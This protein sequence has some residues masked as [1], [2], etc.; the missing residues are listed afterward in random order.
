MSREIVLNDPD[1][2]FAPP[3]LAAAGRGREEGVEREGGVKFGGEGGVG[4]IWE[5]GRERKS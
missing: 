5:G 2:A 4:E 1:S 3:T